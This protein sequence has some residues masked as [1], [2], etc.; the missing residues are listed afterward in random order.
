MAIP[1]PIIAGSSVGDPAA[2]GGTSHPAPEL[3]G[4]Y[5]KSRISGRQ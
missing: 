4:S 2:F 1:I 5:P 3:R